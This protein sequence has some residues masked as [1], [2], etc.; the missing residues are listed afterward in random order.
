MKAF[1][2]NFAILAAVL[3]TASYSY[4]APVCNVSNACE[5]PAATAQGALIINA[6]SLLG[7]QS[8]NSVGPNGNQVNSNYF[9]AVTTSN[10]GATVATINNS[11]DGTTVVG[12]TPT[13]NGSA[14]PGSSVTAGSVQG[15]K[16]GTT[17]NVYAQACPAGTSANGTNCSLWAK[18]DASQVTTTA[19]PASVFAVPVKPGDATTVSIRARTAV[20]AGD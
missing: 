15:T 3:A 17:Y 2:K 16:G 5:T 18:V 20:P 1:L 7:I 6:A 13:H 14:T 8:L 19:Y 4:A 11:G 10:L 9:F 12:V